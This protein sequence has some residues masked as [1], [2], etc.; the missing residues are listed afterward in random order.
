ML[1]KDSS[2]IDL[3]NSLKFYQDNGYFIAKNIF[4]DE[5][6]QILIDAGRDLPS[7]TEG[8]YR[9]QMMPHLHNPIY[10]QALRKPQLVQV[11]DQLVG[12]KAKGLQTQYFYCKPGTRGFSRHQDNFFVEAPYGAFASAWI[13]LTD[14]YPEKGGLIVY[15]GSHKEGTLPVR[16]I[17]LNSDTGQDP[18]A[19]NEETIVP[20]QYPEIHASVPKGAVLFIHGHVV[21]SS[22]ANTTDEWRYVLLNT[23]IRGGESFRSGNYANREEI[24]L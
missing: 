14:T 4:S 9:P 24:D 7:A 20:E 8:L 1:T 21:H 5:E 12:G 11:I 6:C 2:K 23:Y 19:N 22:N 13:A 15:P 16:K 3:D 10:L 18:N 17:I